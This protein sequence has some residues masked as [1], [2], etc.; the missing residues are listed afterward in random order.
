MHMTTMWNLNFTDIKT[1]EYKM[2]AHKTN[3]G[4]GQG[5]RQ[6]SSGLISWKIIWFQKQKAN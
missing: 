3:G 5:K 6:L 4:G 1:A 2:H